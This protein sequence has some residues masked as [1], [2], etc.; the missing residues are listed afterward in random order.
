MLKLIIVNL[1]FVFKTY[2]NLINNYLKIIHKL[3]RNVFTCMT[4]NHTN[5]LQKQTNISII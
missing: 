4:I 5:K 1:I 3:L 2:Q